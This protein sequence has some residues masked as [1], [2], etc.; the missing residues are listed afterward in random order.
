[1]GQRP[2]STAASRGHRAKKLPGQTLRWLAALVITAGTLL[3]IPAAAQAQPAATE[4]AAKPTGDPVVVS[5]GDSYI[6]GT[7]GRWAGN[8]DDFLFSRGGTDRAWSRGKGEFFG[9]SDRGKIYGTTAGGCYRSDS[10][11]II[12]ATKA[13]LTL[14]RP[15]NLACSGAHAANVLRASE[16]GVG[17]RGEKPQDDQLA[18]LARTSRVKLIVLSIGGNDLSFPDLVFKCITAYTLRDDPCKSKQQPRLNVALPAMGAAVGAVLDDVKATMRDA[19]YAD[20]DYRLILQSYPNPLPTAKEDK[21]SGHWRIFKWS[22]G[23][24]PFTDPDETWTATTLTPEVAGTL[25]KTAQR[26]GAS[27]LDLSNA[28]DGH[29]LCAD[30]TSHPIGDPKAK[31]S[32]WV[33][34]VDYS[35]QGEYA[36]SL[37]P[38]YFGQ[39]AVGRCIAK[40]AV[41]TGNSTCTGVPDKGLEGLRLTP[42]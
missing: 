3:A 27:F 24:C 35:G 40:A 32:E 26:H 18:A 11:P 5:L 39:Q 33:R 6:A 7:G 21:Y 37:H 14:G 42:R 20:S 16:G 41:A 34:F 15:V 4:A 13:G 9:S 36:E 23:R 29:E 1:V 25:E 19:G 30:G 10:A 38:N 17:M 22:G 12:S 2:F 31:D 28:F 8:S